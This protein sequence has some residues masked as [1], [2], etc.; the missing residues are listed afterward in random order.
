MPVNNETP[1]PAATPS[2]TWP[3]STA[4]DSQGFL[5]NRWERRDGD[6]YASGA[7][8]RGVSGPNSP[9]TGGESVD[10]MVAV[11]SGVPRVAQAVNPSG[12]LRP[13]RRG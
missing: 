9:I 1:V 11:S 7:A 2:P 12:S 8:T 4:T 5:S 13:L 6:I 3:W 10:A